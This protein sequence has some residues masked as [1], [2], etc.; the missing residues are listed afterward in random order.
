MTEDLDEQIADLHYAD[1][2]GYATGHG[3]SAEWHTVDGACHLLRT[4]WI[5]KAEVEK[6]ETRD[7]PSA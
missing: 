7:V 6:T 1:T 2:P 5:P 4:T 3:V